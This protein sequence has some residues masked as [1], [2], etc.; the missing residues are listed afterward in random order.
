[1]AAC[2][3]RTKERYLERFDAF[4]TEVS[5]NHRTFSERDWERKTA[6]FER[7]SGEWF[8]RFRDDFTLRE[9]ASIRVKQVRWHYFRRLNQ[10]P[11]LL[12]GLNV[13]ELTRQVQS[14]ISKNNIDDLLQLYEEAVRTGREAQDAINEILRE[15]QIDINSLR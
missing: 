6:Q 12:E 7:F 2:A 14:F 11:S 4:I 15:L 10:A 8:D 5:Q 3:P 1:M 13:R 9:I